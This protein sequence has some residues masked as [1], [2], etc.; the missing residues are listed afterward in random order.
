MTDSKILRITNRIYDHCEGKRAFFAMKEIARYHRIQASEGYREA[1]EASC[2]LLRAAGL[3]ARILNYPADLKSVCFTQRIFRE[4]NCKEAWLD[5]TFPWKERAACFSREEMSL[6]QRSAPADYSQADLPVVYV[7]DDME[8]ER[9]DMDMEGKLLFVENGFD[10]WTEKA[11]ECRAAAILTVSMPEIKPVRV[12]MSED[13]ELKEAH[14]NLSFHH[15]TEE[16][17]GKLRGFALSPRFGKELREACLSLAGEGRYPTARFR[18]ESSFQDGF[19]ENVEAYIPGESEEEILLTAHLCHP[20]SSVND[21]ASGAACGIEA[22][23][24]LHALIEEGILPKPKRT[25]RLLLIPEF[26]GT[27][28]YLA[29]NKQR[30]GKIVSGFNIDMVAGRQNGSAGPL[31]LVDT[32][33]CARSFSGDLGEAVLE[34]LSGECA[35]GGDKIAVPLFSSVR[36]PFVF[37][38]DHYILSD[39]TVDI[40]TVALTQWPD[41]TYHTSADCA[42]HV[43]PGLLRRAAAAAAA[44]CYIYGSLTEELVRELLPLT[45][46]RFFARIDKLRRH[47][48]ADSCG[49]ARYLDR[50]IEATLQR[51]ASLFQG[52]ERTAVEELLKQERQ[53]YEILLRG[54]GEA[55]AAKG[56]GPVPRR[57]FQGP[58]AMR[59]ILAGMTEEQ[60]A[61]WDAFTKQYPRLA[62]NMDYIFYETDGVRSIEEVAECVRC[63]TDADCLE[64]LPAFYE[65]FE[66]LGLIDLGLAEKRN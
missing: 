17:E 31:I 46:R 47:A 44:Y 62:A 18:I 60:R 35:F 10:R 37:G 63:Q 12:K 50:V 5:L 29:E 11:K 39:P 6:I 20:R 4:W 27:Y 53:L 66:S 51:Y 14:A 38:S 52:E 3:K 43:D 7:P 34:A 30:L 9:F 19:I 28:A 45:A 49:K 55:A 54:F 41:K 59:C 24:A 21:N 16:S 36:V 33:D 48:S 15:Y 25:I 13:E 40:P 56:K 61:E 1:A 58:A 64:G 23:T 32:P 2:G 42:G 65:L 8:P 57:L 22:M 26:T